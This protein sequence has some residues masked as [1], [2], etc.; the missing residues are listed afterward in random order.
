[1]VARFGFPAIPISRWHNVQAACSHLALPRTLGKVLPVLGA[2][3]VKDDAGRRLVLSLS[4]RERKT[5]QYPDL[6][7]EALERVSDYNKID[8]EG[9]A[10][11]H[12]ATGVLSGRERQVWELDQA[13]NARGIGID[14][15]FVRAAKQIAERSKGA[16]L[17]EFAE[18]TGGLSPHQVGEDPRVAERAAASPSDNLQDDTVQEALDNLDLPRDVARVLQIRLIAAPTSL[19][20]LDAML[21]CVGDD[22]RARGLFQYHAATPGRWSATLIQPQNLP[23][24]TV[25]IDPDE[26][27]DLV[28][29]IKTGDP[30]AL[31]PLGR[32]RS[33]CWRVRCASR[34]VAADGSLFGVGDF[35]MIETCILLALA[36]Q[37]DKC[38]ADRRRRRHLSRHGRDD[39]PARPRRLS[40]DPEGRA[41]ART[42]RAAPGRQEHGP[43]LRVQM[44]AGH[45][46][47]DSTCGTCPGTRPSL[48]R[49]DRL[50]RITGK[51]GRQRCQSC[52]ATSNRP[53]AA[54]CCGRALPP[55]PNAGSP[56]G[57]KRKPA[58]RASSAR[59]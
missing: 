24:P 26:I 50:H 7:P 32:S 42:E 10:A 57:S 8:V 2:D 15:E 6:T 53:R 37:H 28:A 52:G 38:R 33:R 12:A 22:G 56:T 29:A 20:K 44:G 17:D 43:R 1:M 34:I 18:L 35:S 59:C 30:D 4:R 54:R 27:E 51:T 14:V 49:A 39:L 23:R 45:V 36:G 31:R 5:G 41:D 9:L 47:G 21:A 25:D 16:L 46:S 55:T 48:R 58:C 13:I 19:K 40:R 3:V 11:I